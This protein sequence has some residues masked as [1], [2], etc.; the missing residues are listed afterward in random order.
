MDGNGD[1]DGEGMISRDFISGSTRGL[2]EN[3]EQSVT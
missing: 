3:A 2:E 1:S